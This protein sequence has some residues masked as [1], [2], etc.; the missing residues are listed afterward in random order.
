MPRIELADEDVPVLREFLEA[1][2]H[3]LYREIRH[4]DSRAF[5]ERL[6]AKLALIERLLDQLA[7]T[8]TPRS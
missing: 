7:E 3:D 4:T 6:R 5:K 8:P 2:Q 1:E